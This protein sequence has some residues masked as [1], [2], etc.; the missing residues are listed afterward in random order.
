MTDDEADKMM[1]DVSDAICED[2][3]E[4]AAEALEAMANAYQQ[5]FGHRGEK[6]FNDMRGHLV[7]YTIERLGIAAAPLI[8]MTL[9]LAEQELMRKRRFKQENHISGVNNGRI[10]VN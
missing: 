9:Q 7:Q 4:R 5:A 1:T 10:I 8:Q 3:P 2:N 6:P